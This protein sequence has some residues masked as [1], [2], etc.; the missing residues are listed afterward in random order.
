MESDAMTTA[1]LKTVPGHDDMAMIAAAVILAWIY[2][3][4]RLW[5]IWKQRRAATYEDISSR[6]APPR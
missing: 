5:R 1:I 4:V 6:I 2:G 3:F